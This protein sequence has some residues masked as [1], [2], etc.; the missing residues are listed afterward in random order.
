[1]G[2]LLLGLP[3][4]LTAAQ[5]LWINVITDG[6]PAIALSNEAHDQK[7]LEQKPNNGQKHIID[8]HMRIF[9][10]L[11]S[12]T[13]AI[14]GLM[15]FVIYLPRVG[16]DTARTMTF[17]VLG[18]STLL[19]IFSVRT[20]KKPLWSISLFSNTFLV[21]AF[22]AGLLFQIFAVVYGPLQAILKTRT[23]SLSLWLIVIFYTF[24]IIILIEI[25]KIVLRNRK[26]L[27]VKIDV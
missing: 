8:A 18:L 22:L 19:Y 17:S 16:L 3:L 26:I 9:I 1:M 23:L 5:I 14:I 24:L 13:T 7:L 4:P 12:I 10:F 15:T 25:F 21:I 20:L 27:Q 11:I 6:L 2:T